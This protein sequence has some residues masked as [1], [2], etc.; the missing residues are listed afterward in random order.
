MFGTADAT[1]SLL[2]EKEKAVDD[3]NV[4]GRYGSRRAS[5]ASGSVHDPLRDV[6]TSGAMLEGF[7]LCA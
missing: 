3:R 4:A 6:G 2:S 7:D 5:H 1:L